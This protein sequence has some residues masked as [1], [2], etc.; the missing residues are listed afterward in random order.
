MGKQLNPRGKGKLVLGPS[1]RVN[2]L[3]DP[4]MV[5]SKLKGQVEGCNPDASQATGEREVFKSGPTAG[6]P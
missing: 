3:M 5:D 2:G 4:N 1:N 6:K